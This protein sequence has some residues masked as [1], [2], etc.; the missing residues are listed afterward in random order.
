MIWTRAILDGLAL[1]A[2]FNLTIA[3]LWLIM[4]NAFSIMLPSEIKKAAPPREKREVISLRQCCIR[5]ISPYS[6]IWL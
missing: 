2:V 3:L 6:F 5:C 1:C 4:P